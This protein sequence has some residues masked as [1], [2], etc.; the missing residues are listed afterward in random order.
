MLYMQLLCSPAEEIGVL[1]KQKNVNPVWPVT[2]AQL[3]IYDLRHLKILHF[4]LNAED[5]FAECR[6][7]I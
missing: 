1:P 2:W 4:T 6:G 7:L 3:T 5:C